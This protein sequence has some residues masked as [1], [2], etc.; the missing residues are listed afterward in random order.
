M[1]QPLLAPDSTSGAFPIELGPHTVL[2]QETLPQM[3][4]L[5]F[6]SASLMRL[7]QAHL[8]STATVWPPVCC[9]CKPESALCD[10][11]QAIARDDEQGRARPESCRLPVS[12]TGHQV[13]HDP[14][15][16]TLPGQLSNWFF[17]LPSHPPFQILAA[18]LRHEDT[19]G[20]SVKS[21]AD[22]HNQELYTITN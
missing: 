7:P 17:P 16:T 21:F 12:P 19:T 22:E 1:A 18:K 11:P 14:L 3:Q 5:E 8:P 13:Q 15:T 20:R 9:P 4:D 10:P 2:L 6:V